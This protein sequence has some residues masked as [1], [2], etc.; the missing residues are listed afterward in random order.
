MLRKLLENSVGLVEYDSE[1]MSPCVVLP[2]D[3][4]NMVLWRP[5]AMTPAPDFTDFP[6][7]PDIVEF[8]TSFWGKGWEG[9]H[10]DEAVML[11]V[12]WNADELAA[13]KESLTLHAAAGAPIFIA[14]TDSDLYF[15]VD[16][17]SGAV[18]LFEPGDR[19]SRQVAPSLGAFLASLE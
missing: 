4:N 6:L 19:P 5:V 12:P 3:A 13:I 2:P 8:Y 18:W 15:G 14:N 9:N 16:N 7:R 1:W 11:C 17:S 10:S